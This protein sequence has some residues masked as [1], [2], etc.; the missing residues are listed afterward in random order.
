MNTTQMVEAKYFVQNKNRS[1][2]YQFELRGVVGSCRL[3][4]GHDD[5][6]GGL[7]VASGLAM[8]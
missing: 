7:L 6:T 4:P 1:S 5:T 3:I 8:R 2:R